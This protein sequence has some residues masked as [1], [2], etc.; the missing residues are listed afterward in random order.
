MIIE[1]LEAKPKFLCECGTSGQLD[2]SKNTSIIDFI[3]SKAAK[4]QTMPVRCSAAK[5]KNVIGWEIV[6]VDPN[7]YK[8]FN[9]LP[10]TLENT[11][12]SFKQNPTPSEPPLLTDELDDDDKAWTPENSADHFEKSN[13]EG[14]DTDDQAKNSKR[15]KRSAASRKRRLA[16]KSKRVQKG[17]TES[18]EVKGAAYRKLKQY[19]C[20]VSDCR[21]PFRK[22]HLLKNHERDV[23][24]GNG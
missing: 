23:H 16:G 22:P 20:P 4:I 18:G 11:I 19:Y 7:K 14:V 6:L 8:S 13:T 2:W 15:S 3:A 17:K 1:I 9:L 24:L 10:Q 5:N 12:D 21:M